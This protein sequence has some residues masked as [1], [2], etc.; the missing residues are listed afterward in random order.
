[1]QTIYKYNELKAKKWFDSIGFLYDL[2]F[3]NGD[4]VTEKS[5]CL[6]AVAVQA[7]T[8]WQD[9]NNTKKLIIEYTTDKK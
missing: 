2:P 6:L 9:F 8:G 1:M 4:T 7:A 5:I 3:K